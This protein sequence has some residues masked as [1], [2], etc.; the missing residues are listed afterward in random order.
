MA[1]ERYVPVPQELLLQQLDPLRVCRP[2]QRS[3]S[4]P[5]GSGF[6]SREQGGCIGPEVDDVLPSGIERR[7]HV[8]RA[9]LV[10]EGGGRNR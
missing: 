2:G 3:R 5:P 10:T 9:D 8:R 6:Q 1:V 7:G 4:A